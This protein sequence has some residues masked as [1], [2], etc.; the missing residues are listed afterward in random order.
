MRKGGQALNKRKIAYHIGNDRDI[1]GKDPVFPGETY[2]LTYMGMC[3]LQQYTASKRLAEFDGLAGR[4]RKT[5]SP[6][7]T[8]WLSS[9]LCWSSL[10]SAAEICVSF[11]KRK[12][13]MSFGSIGIDGNL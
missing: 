7:P 8:L 2:L 4:Q 5:G 10:V 1:L 6:I 3:K 13:Q 11:P 9:T 12:K